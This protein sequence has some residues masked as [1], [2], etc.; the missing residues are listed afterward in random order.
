MNDKENLADRG[1]AAEP[2]YM[3]DMDRCRPG[4]ALSPDAMRGR[5]RMLD[6]ET[7]TLSGVMLMAGS[8]TDAPEITYALR[9]SGW[10]AISIGTWMMK[11]WYL[12]GGSLE[13]RV[14]LSGE[15]TFSAMVLPVVPPPTKPLVEWDRWTGGEELQESFWKVAD[16]T[17]QE[18]VLGQNA[19]RVATGDGPG[20]LQCSPATIA[21]IKL[22]PLSDEEVSA[23]QADR[24]RTDTR[25]LFAH[26]DF[27]YPTTV[28]EIRR[29]IEPFRDSDFSRIY[30]EGGGGDLLR[31]PSN[32]GRIPTHDGLDDFFSQGPRINAENWRS[33]RE[34]GVDGFQVALDYTHEIGLEAHACFRVAGFHSPPPL[35]YED[36]GSSFYQAHP[37]LRG[38]DRNGNL[39]PRLAFSYPETR[40][41][42]ISL[43]REMAGY[44][45][46]GI[47]LL[48][49]RRPPLV[50]Y[51]PP[52]I[53]GFKA[54][55][56]E[57]PRQ[58]DERD[59]RWLSYRARIL[60]QFM[61]EVRQAMDAVAEEKGRSKRI[62]ITAITMRNE[63]EN[64]VNGMDLQAW[65]DE[66]LVDTLIPFTSEPNLNHQ[67]EA[68]T[69]VTKVDYFL[70]LTRGTS[71]RLAVSIQ[72]THMSAEGY[73]RRADALYKAGVE[74]LF[75]WW[76]DVA[77]NAN[78]K[79]SWSALRRLGNQEEIE[80]WVKA[81][82]PSLAAPTMTVRKLDDWLTS[83]VT[84]G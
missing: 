45:I 55:Y 67:A 77:S 21:Y 28:E 1:F 6:Y 60:T 33:L 37:E 43:L 81:G 41:Y 32:I 4:S 42:V 49:N 76:A 79:G 34:R 47:C 29:H 52:L 31:Y 64:L 18:L 84:P 58:L 27:V 54:E 23:W 83:Y 5:W 70:S 66:G 78:Y 82:E 74:S 8:E 46:D 68:W 63:E 20:S 73:R 30:F 38:I 48:Y 39:T 15:Q 7:D 61:R 75:F 65:V 3:S 16:L 36:H 2:I 53:D 40:R 25:R 11:Q 9:V 50:E 12:S 80:A 26:N 13:L 24:K 22:V 57:D 10:H 14:K 62:E 71:C 56:G 35:D 72:P 69:D 17:G 19:W 51:E 59:P 44:D